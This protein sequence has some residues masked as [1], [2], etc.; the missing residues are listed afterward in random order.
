[1]TW[2]ICALTWRRLGFSGGAGITPS[3]LLR[4]GHALTRVALMTLSG[5]QNDVSRQIF[6][7]IQCICPTS[8]PVQSCGM[9]VMLNVT[10]R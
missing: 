6:C 7:C 8:D 4:V 3:R 2:Q 5:V 9:H 10:S 1:M